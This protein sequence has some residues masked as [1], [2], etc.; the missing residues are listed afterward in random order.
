MIAA[1]IATAIAFGAAFVLTFILR[2]EDQTETITTKEIE[3]NV[4]N[5]PIVTERIILSSPLTGSV[6]PLNEVKDQVFSSGQWA[7]G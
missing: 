2:F 4:P 6:M 1:S 5:Q 7:K 3:S